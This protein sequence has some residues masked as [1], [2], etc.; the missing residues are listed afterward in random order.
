MTVSAF[1]ALLPALLGLAALQGAGDAPQSRAV[2]QDEIIMRVP[3]RPRLPAPAIEWKERKGP[4]CVP[5]DHIRAA[6]LSGPEEVDFL[7]KDRGRVR[8]ELSEDCPALDFYGGFYLQT[9]DDR[10]CADRD[11]IHSRIGGSC[12]IDRFRSL[13]PKLR[14]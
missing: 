9:R 8:A 12:K 2:I 7:L 6:M 1:L 4:K 11:V 5:L 3:V 14:R 10:M 13:E